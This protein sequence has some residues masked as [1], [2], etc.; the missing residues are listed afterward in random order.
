L[1]RKAQRDD[2]ILDSDAPSLFL[3][4]IY[5]EMRAVH[6][7]LAVWQGKNEALTRLQLADG[8]GE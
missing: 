8:E 3:A 2:T 6:F 7:K 5:R 4:D 1:P